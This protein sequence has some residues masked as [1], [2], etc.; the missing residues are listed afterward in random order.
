MMRGF[1]AA[2]L[3]IA[4][5]SATIPD[6]HAARRNPPLPYDLRLDV[7][8]GERRNRESIR[9]S[10]EQTLIETMTEQTCFRSVSVQGPSNLILTIVLNDLETEQEYAT[11]SSMLPGQGEQHMLIA[12]RASVDL[13]Y[14]LSPD[15][16][17]APAILGG[18]VFRQIT[19]EAT[20]PADPAESR[21]LSELVKDASRWVARRLCDERDALAKK[22]TKGLA[23]LESGETKETAPPDPIDTT[24]AP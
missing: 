9:A 5:L 20:A 22:I 19:R 3:V 17:E 21:A 6:V 18:H 12:A 8:W 10:F 14:D 2:A 13:D 24:P 23:S 16:N 4:G 15:R 11:V 1:I 7:R